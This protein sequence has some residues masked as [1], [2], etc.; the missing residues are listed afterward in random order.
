MSDLKG[1]PNT[2]LTPV[3]FN[4]YFIRVGLEI[5][6]TAED[7]RVTW[8]H[9]M[10]SVPSNCQRSLFLSPVD[11]IKDLNKINTIKYFHAGDIY[12]L[13]TV[14]IKGVAKYISTLM[15]ELINHYFCEGAFQKNMKKTVAKPIY[16]IGDTSDPS[17]WR[18]TI[19]LFK[20]I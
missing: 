10:S 17:N 2:S 12:S 9:P 3:M 16:K 7:V 11:E 5:S 20:N 18:S 15:C 8:E 14:F 19:F 4:E 6:A 13:S 1:A